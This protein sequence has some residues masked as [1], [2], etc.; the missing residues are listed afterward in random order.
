[1]TDKKL[2]V[3][4][5][6]LVPLI[7]SLVTG[8]VFVGRLIER[9][10]DLDLDALDEWKETTRGELAEIARSAATGG[11]QAAWCDVKAQRRKAETYMNREPYAIEVAVSAGNDEFCAVLAVV[12]DKQILYEYEY[13]V[14]GGPRT[15]GWSATGCAAQFTVPAGSEYRVEV[16]SKAFSSGPDKNGTV[17]SWYE[18]TGECPAQ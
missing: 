13:G 2:L 16:D 10:D 3:R 8:V 5:G 4:W 15:A 12:D 14:H 7:V 6:V 11:V 1:M 17:Y 18:L 9:V